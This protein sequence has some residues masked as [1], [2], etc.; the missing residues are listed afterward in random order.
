MA[1][2]SLQQIWKEGAEKNQVSVSPKEHRRCCWKVN[3]FS[4]QD[5]TYFLHKNFFFYSDQHGFVSIW[6]WFCKYFR[7][8]CSNVIQGPFQRI[9]ES[10][11]FRGSKILGKLLFLK[12]YQD[13]IWLSPPPPLMSVQCS[14]PEATWWMI[15]RETEYRNTRDQLSS[16]KPDIK[17][18]CK[19]VKVCH[20]L[21]TCCWECKMKQPFWKQSGS[22]SKGVIYSKHMTQQFHS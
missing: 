22:S 13:A 21:H 10:Y 14:F 16:I 11:G 17:Q 2:S 3:W 9:Q 4:A 18:I 5:T 6:V 20:L 12:W 8:W 19:N 15:S 1:E 7:A